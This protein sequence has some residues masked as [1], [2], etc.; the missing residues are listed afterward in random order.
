MTVSLISMF[1]EVTES[2]DIASMA[3]FRHEDMRTGRTVSPN[4]RKEKKVKPEKRI[5]KKTTQRVR[6]KNLLHV[7]LRSLIDLLLSFSSFHAYT[8]VMKLCLSLSAFAG[9]LQGGAKNGEGRRHW[10][11][12][13]REKGLLIDE[14]LVIWTGYVGD[15]V[16][17]R[18]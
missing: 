6:Q 1:G 11:N 2:S 3:E 14:W 10:R 13:E 16:V 8:Y 5:Q 18:Y 4:R 7:L 15:Y 9:W 12:R 17:V